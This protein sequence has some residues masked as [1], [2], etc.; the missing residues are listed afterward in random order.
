M[1]LEGSYR[2]VNNT[3]NKKSYIA[4]R[5]ACFDDSVIIEFLETSISYYSVLVLT[6]K[7]E[8]IFLLLHGNAQDVF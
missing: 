1:K 3:A 4:T 7:F 6:L 5:F 8:S 2:S